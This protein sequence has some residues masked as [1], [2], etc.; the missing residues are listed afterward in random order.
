VL[1]SKEKIGDPDSLYRMNI[2]GTNR[3]QLPRP[4]GAGDCDDPSYSPDGQEIAFICNTGKGY[5]AYVMSSSGSD[6]Q[7]L[8]IGPDG[9]DYSPILTQ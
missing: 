9:N 2:D 8:D 4:N 3:Q 6:I 5:D 7:Q 1:I